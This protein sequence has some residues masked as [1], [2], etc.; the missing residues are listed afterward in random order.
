M[1]TLKICRIKLPKQDSPIG[2]SL[3]W[4]GAVHSSSNSLYLPD[5]AEGKVLLIDTEKDRI[6]DEVEGTGS[7]SMAQICRDR[8]LV[9]LT[10]SALNEALVYKI[11]AI[12]NLLTLKFNFPPTGLSLDSDRD[13]LLA[14]GAEEFAFYRYPELKGLDFQRPAGKVRQAY[15]DTLE[16]AFVILLQDPHRLMVIKSGE[17]LS[18]MHDVGFGS[19]TIN[20]VVICSVDRKVVLG[21]EGGK[22]LVTGFDSQPQKLAASFKEPVAKLVYNSYV[23]HLYVMFRGSRHLAVVDMETDKV[24]E[25]ERCGS[26]ISD[27]MFDELHNKIYALLPSIPALEVYLDMGR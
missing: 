2:M 8:D 3:P 6:K 16:D 4:R 15:F 25:V 12:R 19:E 24:R 17:S 26:E 10:G 18:V 7:N 9:F 27:I 11:G 5:P 23:N 1:S 14:S 13:V 20:A 22:I 21:T